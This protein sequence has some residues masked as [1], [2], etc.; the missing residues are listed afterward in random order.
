MTNLQSTFGT[1]TTGAASGS[2][3]KLLRGGQG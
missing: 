3:A 1:S 2:K